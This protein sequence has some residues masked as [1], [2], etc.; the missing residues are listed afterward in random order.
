MKL[1]LQGI[2]NFI[3]EE[4]EQEELEDAG[5]KQDSIAFYAI[6]IRICILLLGIC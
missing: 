3:R 5:A 4:F 1:R 2:C 6:I